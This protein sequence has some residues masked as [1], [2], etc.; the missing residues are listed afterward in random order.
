LV[1]RA[2]P[3]AGSLG[4]EWSET[5]LGESDGKNARVSVSRPNGELELIERAVPEPGPREVRIKVEACG[6][7]H[8]D[9]AVVQGYIP[10][11]QYPRVP[12]HEVIG[13]IDALGSG[14]TDW[15]DGQRVGVGY[16]G[17]YDGTCDACRRGDLDM[18]R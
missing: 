2:L 6:V 16:N 4:G 14:V 9:W 18:K 7:C 10:G 17:G 13:T 3:H 15:A 1:E 11:V 8:T 5:S 12:G